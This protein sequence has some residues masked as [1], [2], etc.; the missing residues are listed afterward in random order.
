MKTFL[1]CLGFVMLD[2]I[3]PKSCSN[4]QPRYYD[5]EDSTYY[6]DSLAYEEEMEGEDSLK[7][8]NDSIA[9]SND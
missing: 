5:D 2:A 4:Q 6:E 3:V 1:F 8:I 9:Q 7:S